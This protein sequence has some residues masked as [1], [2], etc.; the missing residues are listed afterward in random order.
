MSYQYI[1]KFENSTQQFINLISKLDKEIIDSEIDKIE[2]LQQSMEEIRI[3]LLKKEL[4]KRYPNANPPPGL[5][6]LVGSEPK[7]SLKEEK[8]EIRKGVGERF[9]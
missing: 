6:K 1:K 8:G 7:I 2:H 9:A 4:K 3:E 5:L